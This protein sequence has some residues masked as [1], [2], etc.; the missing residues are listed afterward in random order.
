MVCQ[1]LQLHDSYMASFVS[2]EQAWF[3][4]CCNYIQQV[5]CVG[6]KQVQRSVIIRSR[7]YRMLCSCGTS[8]VCEL[9]QLHDSIKSS[10]LG[11]KQAWFVSC[12]NYITAI[13]Q[14]L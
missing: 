12:Y 14:A 13:Q 6:N 4:S 5:L 7:L 9:V 3:V 8:M 2:V 1:L 11:V 10:F